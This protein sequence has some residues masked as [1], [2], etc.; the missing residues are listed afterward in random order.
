MPQFRFFLA[1]KK[2]QR[3]ISLRLR[4]DALSNRRC[5]K[6]KIILIISFC[7]TVLGN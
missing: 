3:G 4:S 6:V 2:P 5:N 1:K 7:N